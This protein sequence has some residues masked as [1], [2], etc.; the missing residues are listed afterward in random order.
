MSGLV[1]RLASWEAGEAGEAGG[2]QAHKKK[3]LVP[4]PDENAPGQPGNEEGSPIQCPPAGGAA[5]RDVWQVTQLH[6]KKLR[7]DLEHIV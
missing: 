5:G 3:L 4:L 7:P 6:M 2:L 1:W